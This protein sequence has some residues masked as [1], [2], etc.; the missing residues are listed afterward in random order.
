VALRLLAI[1]VVTAALPIHECESQRFA[2]VINRVMVVFGHLSLE[3]KAQDFP[4][5]CL[6]SCLEG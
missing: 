1:L 2:G 4:L 3:S 5:N 6:A